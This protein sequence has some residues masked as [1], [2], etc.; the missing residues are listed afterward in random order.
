MS[1][2][3]WDPFEEVGTLRRSMERVFDDFFA[4]RRALREK[5]EWTLWE[6]PVEMFETKD[7]VVVRA[8]LPNIDPDQI[9]VTVSADAATLKGETK[10]EEEHRDRNYHRR[11][12]RYGAFTRTVPLAA[13]VKSGEA[14]AIYKNGVLEVTIPKSERVKSTPVKVEIKK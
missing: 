4:P 1:I 12:I 7:E 8:E 2:M 11:E 3:R 13:E 14:K 6:P 5:P 10:H 9:E